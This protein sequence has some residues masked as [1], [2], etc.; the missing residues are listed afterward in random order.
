[1]RTAQELVRTVGIGGHFAWE[2][3]SVAHQHD[4]VEYQVGVGVAGD[5]GVREEVV[6]GGAAL[7]GEAQSTYKDGGTRFVE[8]CSVADTCLRGHQRRSGRVVGGRCRDMGSSIVPCTVVAPEQQCCKMDR[9]KGAYTLS[10]VLELHI[11]LARTA[12]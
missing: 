6:H 8:Q 2:A 3:A 12:D 4:L 11:G 1:M 7:A 5:A 10:A 9:R